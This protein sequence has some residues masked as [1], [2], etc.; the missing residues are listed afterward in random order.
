MELTLIKP[1]NLKVSDKYSA[2]LYKYLKVNPHSRIY[3]NKICS[4]K[5]VPLTYHIGKLSVY[6][7]YVGQLGGGFLTGN[8]LMSI[9]QKPSKHKFAFIKNNSELEDITEQFL[10]D[11]ELI[12]RCLWYG[13]H[14]KRQLGDDDRFAHINENKRICNWCGCIQNKRIEK[15]VITKTHVIWE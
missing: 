2:N 13:D 7:A 11:Y 5:E 6:N 10:L 4:I 8:N 9:L 1:K 14:N 3:M 15:E 12:G